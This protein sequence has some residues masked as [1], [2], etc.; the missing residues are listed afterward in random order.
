MGGDIRPFCYVMSKSGLEEIIKTGFTAL[1]TELLPGVAETF[2]IYYRELESRNKAFNL[3]AIK[4]ETDTAELHFLDCVALLSFADF[5]GKS[6]IDIGTGAG[7]PGLPLKIAEPTINLTLLDS[8]LKRMRFLR[9]LCP[10]LGFS[11]VGFLAARAEDIKAE[12][13]E[14][15]DIAVSR[16]VSPLN[17]LC[18]LC[19][20]YIKPGGVFIAMKGPD[21]TEEIKEAKGAVFVLGGAFSSV[22]HYTVPGTD[23]KR[24]AVLIK[25]IKETPGRYPRRFARIKTRP[26][27]PSCP[28]EAEESQ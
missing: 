17:M 9:E 12:Q 23:K 25:K 11:D 22:I 5:G 13:R 3:T 26:L 15:F 20:P 28:D 18:E 1:G 4:G 6:V 16:A 8:S 24:S 19:M 21:P 27:Q 2:G 10:M 14:I 7:F